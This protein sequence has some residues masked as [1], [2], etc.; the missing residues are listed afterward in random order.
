MNNYNQP[1]LNNRDLNSI[2][3]INLNKSEK[4]QEGINNM[5]LMMWNRFLAGVA[6]NPHMTKKQVCE[7]LGLKIGTINSIQKYHNLSS[8]FYFK[9][10]TAHR[11]KNEVT[12]PQKSNKK[13]KNKVIKGGKVMTDTNEYD[14]EETFNKTVNSLKSK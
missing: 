11:K 5:R 10:P 14:F 7:Q 1:D 8:P 4:F 6:N 12:E 13:T 2:N 3:Q 9:K